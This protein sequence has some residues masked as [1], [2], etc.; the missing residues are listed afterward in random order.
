[1]STCDTSRVVPVN[2]LIKTY[3]KGRDRIVKHSNFNLPCIGF[4]LKDK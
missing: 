1:M 2:N 4:P 3:E